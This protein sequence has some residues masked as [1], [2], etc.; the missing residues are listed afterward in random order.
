MVGP[1]AVMETVGVGLTVTVTGAEV[2]L[3]PNAFVA[4]TVYVPE[5]FT[6]IDAVVAPVDQR[7]VPPPDAVSVT[8]PPIQKLSGPLAVIFGEGV[9]FTVTVVPA[10]VAEQPFA[11]VA[12]TE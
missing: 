4:L 10:D 6:K 1:L 7:Y 2:P 8:S 9:G 3:H 11:S 5:L 12:V